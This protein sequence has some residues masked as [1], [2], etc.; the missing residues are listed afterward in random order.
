VKQVDH[1]T[2]ETPSESTHSPINKV[3][4]KCPANN[5]QLKILNILP[6]LTSKN[7][8]IAPAPLH[9][10]PVTK[11]VAHAGPPN[12][13]PGKLANSVLLLVPKE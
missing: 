8:W 10:T 1:A 13:T 9:H 3:S 4:L 2:E 6:A 5:T 11:S 12:I 7:V